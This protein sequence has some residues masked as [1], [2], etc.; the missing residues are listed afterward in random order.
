MTTGVGDPENASLSGREATR[1]HPLPELRADCAKC[2]ALCCVVPAF[3]ASADFAI[4][5]PAGRP[6]PNL[7]ADFRCGIHDRL[8]D[9]GFTGCTV[10]DCFGAGQRVAQVTFGGRDWRQQPELA[11]QMFAAFP[12]MRDLHELMWYLTQALTLKQ[13][14]PLRSD[15]Q[16]ALD[17]VER[18]S[19]RDADSL[20]KFD[21]API[22]QKVNALLLEASRLVRGA[23]RLDRSRADL[24]GADLRGHD[25]RH[26]NLRGAYLIGAD[27]RDARLNGADLIGADLRGAKL[28][29][30]DLTGAL[31]ITQAQ[32]DSAQGDVTT[33]LPDALIRPKHWR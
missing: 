20:T 6:C 30:A 27:L 16:A 31:F 23:A 22:W 17:L 13:A 3:S 26:S 11:A 32:L 2:F 19:A 4:D 8:R 1:P 33:R 7:L 25:L 18:E 14:R 29:A 12:V 10:Y 28:H 15:L 9:T 24:I 21:T 5:K